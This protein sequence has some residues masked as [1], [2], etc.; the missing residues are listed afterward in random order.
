MHGQ[1]RRI[2]SK[3]HLTFAFVAFWYSKSHVKV[4]E[5]VYIYVTI[6]VIGGGVGII[7]V[8]YYLLSWS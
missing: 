5:R 2:C 6:V 7:I 1:P 4:L 8:Q 3:L